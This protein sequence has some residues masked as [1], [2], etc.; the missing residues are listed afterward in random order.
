MIMHAL[1][2][3]ALVAVLMLLCPAAGLGQPAAPAAPAA[4]STTVVLA[5]SLGDVTVE[6]FADKA[7]LTVK[8]FL[9]Y[10]DAGFYN[11]TLFHRVI[12]GF[13]IQGGGFGPDMQQKQTRPPVKNEADNGLRNS[14]GTLAMAR[15]SDINSATSQFFVNLT[16]NT[17]LDHQVRDFGYAVF[18]KVVG[19][20]DVVDKIAAVRTGTK[21][22]H[23]NVP[24]EPVAITSAR[25]K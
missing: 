24:L 16:D 12:P 9:E 7:P 20:M 6:L 22:M 19:G 23:Q 25:R 8:N 21:G 4:G 5:T 3:L 1:F 17:F 18:G 10:V 2:S 15:T 14:R 13:M 11:G